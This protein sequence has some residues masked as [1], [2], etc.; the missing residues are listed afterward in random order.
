MFS[1]TIR[2]LDF[3]SSLIK[4]KNLLSRYNPK[5]LDLEEFGP[6]ARLWLNKKTKKEIEKRLADSGDSYVNFLGSGDFH[7]I[8]SLLIDRLREPICVIIFDFHPD[9]DILPP[10]LGCGSWV[11]ETLRSKNILKCILMG[12]SSEDISSFWIQTGNLNSLRNDR[13]EIYPYS[14]AP[15]LTLFK[16]IPVNSSLAIKKGVLLS[17]I[18]WSEL[19][20]K[21]IEDFFPSIV[22][23]LAVKKVYISIDKD[24]L[25]KEFALT[26]WEEGMFSLDELLFMLKVIKEELEIVG[27][28]IV[29]EYSPISADTKLKKLISDFDHPKDIP[30]NGIPEAIITVRNEE[31]N[32]KILNTLN[33]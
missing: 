19:K 2:I 10:R 21:I 30:A 25:K 13:V 26:N 1:K 3:D 27:V 32:L 12:V 33:L 16:K 20:N 29:G 9:W 7:H 11:S 23:R 6:K 4:Q 5:I 14:H 8:S 24:C 31:A 17:K 22:R 15:S 28:D 18:Y